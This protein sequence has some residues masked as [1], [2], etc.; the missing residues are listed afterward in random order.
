MKIGAQLYTVRAFTQNSKDFAACMK[1]IAS[2]GYETVQVS[3]INTA[4]ISPQ[5]VADVCK[6]NN[7]EIVV[8][9][10]PANR[11]KDETATVIAE[12]ELMGAK[13]IGLGSVPSSVYSYNKEG[14]DHFI[15]DMTPAV[16][17]IADAGM[18]FMYHNHEFEFMKIGGKTVLEYLADGIPQ[19]GFTL[20]TFWV[21]VGGGDPAQYIRKLSGRVDIIHLKDL[22]IAPGNERR[23]A[24]FLEGN[25]NW[26][27]IYEAS[28]E[29]GVKY[30][31]VEQDNCYERDPFESMEISFNNLRK[32]G[33]V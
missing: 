22:I 32:K 1:R 21:Q 15:A 19:M 12:H 11:I 2:I 23:M 17:A 6:E 14:F 25:M 3:G 20:D 27:S 28:K 16:K 10:T 5:E 13:Y 18:C 29:S 31:M 8:T 4:E 26:D 24:E 30:A 33:W 9:H 7:L